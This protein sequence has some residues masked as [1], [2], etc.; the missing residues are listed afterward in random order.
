MLDW[1]ISLFSLAL[2]MGITP[3]PNNFIAFAIG[4]TGDHRALFRFAAG[5]LVG[6]SMLYLALWLG[7]DQLVHRYENA[8]FVLKLIAVGLLLWISWKVATAPAPTEANRQTPLGFKGAVLFQVVNPK[9]WSGCL[10]VLGAVG[11]QLPDPRVEL[12]LMLL[13]III[14]TAIAQA[15]WGYG[16]ALIERV[17]SGR[18]HRVISVCLGLALTATALFILIADFPKGV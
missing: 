6:F 3:G 17:L 4:R 18:G 14:V 12:S 15:V 7:L 8:A 16:G 1:F 11:H 2:L 13:T 9:A 5:V 10:A